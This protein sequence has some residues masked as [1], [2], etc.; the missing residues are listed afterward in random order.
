MS[1]LNHSYVK[2]IFLI[3]AGILIGIHVMNG[4]HWAW[5]IPL[6]GAYLLIIAYGSTQIESNYHIFAHCEGETNQK[7]VALTFDDGPVAEF[8]PGVLDLLEEYKVKATFFCIGN[9]VEQASA[10]TQRIHSSGH[11]LGNHTYSHAQ[12]FDLYPQKKMQEELIHT[13]SLIAE[14]TGA[15]PRFFRPPYGVTNPNLRRAVEALKLDVIGWNVRS[16]DTSI[17]DEGKIVRRIMD[18]LQPG[19]I[20]LVHDSHPRIL[21]VLKEILPKIIAQGY[22]FVPLDKLLKLEAYE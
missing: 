16:L 17:M 6:I 19:A 4:L 2:I 3:L 8:T 15:A 18:R 11:L 7:E 20:I 1:W 13:N 5:Y 14:V 22:S 21:P 10:L 9:R 12:L